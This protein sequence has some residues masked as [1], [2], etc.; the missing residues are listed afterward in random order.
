VKTRTLD[1]ETRRVCPSRV[2]NPKWI[3]AM[4]RHGYKGAFELAAALQENSR[5][6][7]PGLRDRSS[8]DKWLS[9]DASSF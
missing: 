8:F 1:E 4:R 9:P 3:A 5:R 2:V 6:T 7:S